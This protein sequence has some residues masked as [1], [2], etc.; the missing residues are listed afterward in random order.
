MEVA[1]LLS[2]P[3]LQPTSMHED[4]EFALVHRQA[5]VEF[6]EERLLELEQR[7]SELQKTEQMYRQRYTDTKLSEHCRVLT[8]KAQ[9]EA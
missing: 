6:R 5:M 4:L 8:K 7:L 1:A 2:L 9:N 3:Q